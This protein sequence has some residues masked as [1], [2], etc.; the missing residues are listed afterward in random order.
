MAFTKPEPITAVATT[1]TETSP[2]ETTEITVAVNDIL[3]AYGVSE[4][5]AA[6]IGISGGITWTSQKKLETA[7]NVF[8]QVWTGKATEAKSFKVKFTRETGTTQ[9]FWGGVQVWRKSSGIGAISGVTNVEGAPSQAL[10]TEKEHSAVAMVISDWNAKTGAATYRTTGLG[11]F[12]EKSHI[13]D[14][15]RYTSYAG[16]YADV[17]TAGA[18]TTGA[19]AP[20]SQKYSIVVVEIKGE[21]SS[22][23]ETFTLASEGT[24]VSSGSETDE[25]SNEEAAAGTSTSSFS[26]V[27]EFTMEESA[28][29]SSASTFS[30]SDVFT[31]GM[32]ASGESISSGEATTESKTEEGE[33][34]T[35]TPSGTS[36]SSGEASSEVIV[37]EKPSGTS[38]SSG[39]ESDTLEFIDEENGTSSSTGSENDSVAFD[40]VVSGES[41]STGSEE[42]STTA[43]EIVEGSSISSGSLGEE[44][45]V[46]EDLQSGSSSSSGSQTTAYSEGEATAP[47]IAPIEER[48]RRRA[49]RWRFILVN[50]SNLEEIGEVKAARNRQV[51]L[52]LDKPGGVQFEVPLDYG[53][54]KNIEEIKHGIIAYRG[55]V[56]KHSGMIWNL[57]EDI[58]NNRLSV[59]STGWFETL[60]HRILRENVG[61]PPFN[62]GM[63]NAG[64]MVFMAASGSVGTSSYHPGGLLT[65]ANAQQDTWIQEGTNKDKMQRILSYAKGQGIGA[66]ISQL[67]EIEAGFDFWI[68]PLTRVMSITGWNEVPDKREQIVFG[69]NW[70]PHNIEKLG[71][72]FDPSQM[73]NRM[74]TLGKFGGGFAEEK[75]AQEEFQLFEEMPQ[76][77]EVTDPNVLLA[78]AGGEVLLRARPRQIYSFT[79]FPYSG[80]KRVPQPLIDYGIGDKVMF[81]A[82]K[83]PRIAI[84]GQAVRV[85]GMTINITDE[86]N[87][88]VSALQIS[89]S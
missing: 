30:E 23:G 67:S 37:E 54:F 82:I 32:E 18:K 26:E 12:T 7:S 25:V 17:E 88:K 39:S 51:Q 34:F 33:T 50:S 73:V 22:E 2:K 4:D 74:T 72:Q 87:E 59:Q 70:G 15:T 52:A 29:G 31:Y 11:T 21:E 24:S 48:G 13:E 19:S 85:Y 38:S 78:Y 9:H 64:Q 5:Q 41:S 86:G 66:A 61:Y 65:I 84:Q 80:S 55:K 44:A 42:D 28:Q 58:D 40:Q 20:G 83:P 71:R 62:T 77:N 75:L 69:Y 6:H 14:A 68:D 53:L 35:F 60:N 8:L 1:S 43:S 36:T 27:D 47:D 49:V 10:T 56:A 57:D 76:L 79:P 45:L 89:P 46:V 81:T 3:V 16:Y 63:V